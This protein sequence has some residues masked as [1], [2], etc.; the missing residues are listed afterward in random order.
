[1]NS[2]AFSYSKFMNFDE[3]ADS[4]LRMMSRIL[5]INTLFIAK[6]D[7]RT[8]EIV[9]VVNHGDTLLREGDTLPFE[10]TFCK[11]SVDYGKKVLFIP[12]ITESDLSHALNVTR[13]LGSG[14][15]VGLPIFYEDGRNYGTIC[16]LDTETFELTE[17][18][19]ELFETMSSLLSYV[20]ELDD[21][22]RQIQTLSAPLVPITT[23]VAILPIIGN[24]NEFRLETIIELALTK[25]ESLSLEYLII[26]LSGILQINDM[27]SSSLL[28]VVSMLRLIGVTPILTG[29]RPDLALRAIS[30]N[31]DLKSVKTEASLESALKTIG[32]TLSRDES[33]NGGTGSS[34]RSLFR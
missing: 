9:K 20:L 15:F 29:I 3:A 23:G 18:H 1:M 13:N 26:D 27:V 33:R 32:F 7:Q 12:D 17:E 4:I 6:N 8:N 25:S 21:A 11:L 2:N 28:K 5:N 22:N 34:S 19:V 24:I 16:G 30:T 10:E 14:S 31:T